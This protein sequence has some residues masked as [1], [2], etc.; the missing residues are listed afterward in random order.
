MNLTLILF[1]ISILSSKCVAVLFSN[2]AKSIS[3]ISMAMII[4]IILTIILFN[5]KIKNKL[6]VVILLSI[7][8]PLITAATNVP[9]LPSLNPTSMPSLSPTSPTLNPTPFPT[10]ISTSCGTNRWCYSIDIYPMRH[11]QTETTVLLQVNN[12][13]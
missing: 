5:K 9:T 12:P 10:Y 6:S 4:L 2:V 8:M 3:I 11:I 1:S 7:N 13:A